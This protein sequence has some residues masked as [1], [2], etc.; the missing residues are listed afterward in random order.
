M[1]RDATGTSRAPR[2]SA[3]PSETQAGAPSSRTPMAMWLSSW[4]VIRPRNTSP[5]RTELGISS[6]RVEATCERSSSLYVGK[7]IA[8]R[9]S[10]APPGHVPEGREHAAGRPRCRR[11]P[12]RT[13]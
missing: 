3:M 1:M 2:Y 6:I 4:R 11:P 8:P 7:V 10:I 9:C 12:S 13:R 5:A